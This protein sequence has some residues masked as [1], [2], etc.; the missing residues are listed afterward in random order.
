MNKPNKKTPVFLQNFILCGIVGWC[1]EILFTA[2]HSLRRRDMRLQGTTSVWMF[3]I[4]GS[5]ALLEPIS[6]LIK[7]RPF[8]I[9][10]L[11]YM[12]LI[13]SAEYITGSLLQSRALCPWDYR[14]SRWNIKRIIRLDYAPYWFGAGLLFETILKSPEQKPSHRLD[15]AGRHAISPFSGK[16]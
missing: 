5:A 14:R 8:W 15:S 9:R 3:P 2:L 1:M 10:G 12:S 6:R 11:L 4:Y 16:H 13:F 7:N